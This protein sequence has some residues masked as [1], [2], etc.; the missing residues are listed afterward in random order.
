MEQFVQFVINHWELCSAFLVLLV[1]FIATEASGKVRGIQQITAQ[2]L[3]EAIN[4]QD[5]AVLDVRDA[6]AFRQGHITG[7]INVPSAEIEAKL[8]KLEKYRQK[9]VI[10]ACSN[11]QHAIKTALIL[12]KKGF[13]NVASLKGGLNAW[14]Q[15]SLPLVK[16]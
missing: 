3:T 5:A 11:G 12:R 15:A 9:P 14:R 16:G 13:E 4:H 1:L 8:K 6:A 7:A 2:A 10:I